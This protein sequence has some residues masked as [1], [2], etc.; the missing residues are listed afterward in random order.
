MNWRPPAFAAGAI[1][2]AALVWFSS[3]YLLDWIG[4]SDFDPLDRICLVV[5]ILSISEAVWM[6]FKPH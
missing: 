6:R 2:I 5:L 1:G 4:L 3:A